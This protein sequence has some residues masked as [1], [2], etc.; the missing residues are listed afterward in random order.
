M[1]RLAL[2][3]T[4]PLP[5]SP[6][7]IAFFR[8]QPIVSLLMSEKLESLKRRLEDVLDDLSSPR[9]TSV[10]KTEALR[11]LE[12][13]LAAACARTNSDEDRDVFIALQ[14]TFE[15][16]VSTK[17]LS[18]IM[19]STSAL[20]SLISQGDVDTERRAEI[21][22]ITAQL[23][24][25]LSILQGVCLI[26]PATKASLGCRCAL[27]VILDLFLASRHLSLPETAS[28]ANVVKA[29]PLASVILDTLLCVLVDSS[30]ALR[31]FE[32]CQGVH[33]V[34]K[35]LKRAGTPREVRMKCLEFLYFYL[36]DETN[37]SP[38]SGLPSVTMH[39]APIDSAPSTPRPLPQHPSSHKPFINAVPSR[40]PS[41]YGSSTYSFSSGSTSFDS[42]LSSGSFDTTTT[43]SSS[44]PFSSSPSSRSTSGSS[45]SSTTSAVGSVSPKKRS[46][47]PPGAG[48]STP[49]PP[50]PKK[51][52][53]ALP[54][55]PGQARL[56]NAL[57]MLRKDVEFVPQS[58]KRPPGSSSSKGTLQIRSRLGSLRPE[59]VTSEE[60]DGDLESGSETACESSRGSDTR[61][62][63]EKKRLLGT[64]LGNV[65]ALVEGVKKAGIWG[66]G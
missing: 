13:I 7:G 58:P 57:L 54:R 42:S 11:S 5:P 4:Q 41:R 6:R 36:L 14:Y 66:L 46:Q 30:P 47:F 26:H 48:P 28:K 53:S 2:A 21:S 22:D 12:R 15:C 10:D 29:Q 27:E 43:S 24:L 50:S 32:S 51:P 61:T 62:T 31:L 1:T 64:M 23:S 16:N 45:F 3:E 20:E 40:P 65:E 60:S 25:A 38:V 8:A 49:G 63:E 59:V 19:A 33:A 17:I 18:W 52:S 37:V 55:T 56:P 35:I 34:V 44:S 9:S 39:K